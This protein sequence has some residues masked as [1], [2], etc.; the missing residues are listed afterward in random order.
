[1][2]LAWWRIQSN[3]KASSH[4][5]QSWLAHIIKYMRKYMG[6]HQHSRQKFIYQNQISMILTDDP[7]VTVM[8]TG[9]CECFNVVGKSSE[10]PHKK[11]SQ[12]YV[13]WLFILLY[14]VYFQ[15][16]NA[17]GIM[18]VCIYIYVYTHKETKSSLK[19]IK[20]KTI[21]TGLLL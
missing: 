14:Y 20:L 6:E 8:M 11:Y 15:Y 10:N 18:Y 5:W 4:D 16:R 12:G 9:I 13:V 21:Y 3:L 2:Q 1:M 19:K 17:F 7:G